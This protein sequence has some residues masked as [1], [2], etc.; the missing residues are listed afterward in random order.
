MRMSKYKDLAVRNPEGLLWL[1]LVETTGW[2]ELRQRLRLGG[3][4]WA[5][6]VAPEVFGLCVYHLGLVGDWHDLG[7]DL[8]R[9]HQEVTNSGYFRRSDSIPPELLI[10]DGWLESLFQKVNTQL[11][12]M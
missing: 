7:S 3:C 5:V 10:V 6:G 2:D 11:G 8:E 9:L 4:A 1:Q 12:H